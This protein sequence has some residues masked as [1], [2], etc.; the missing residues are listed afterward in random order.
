[1]KRKSLVVTLSLFAILAGAFASPASAQDARVTVQ[2]QSSFDKTIDQL[3]GAVSKGGMMVMGQVDQGNMLSM[4]GL[5]LKAT[6]FLVG[7][8]TVGK[9]LFEQDHG[10]GLYVPF[11]VFVTEGK[12]GK[13]YVSYDKASALLRQ[14]KNAD[15]DKTAAML[16]Q[17]LEGMAQMA[18]K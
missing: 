14:F 1:M 12:D 17:K 5:K 8:P 9:Q 13:V 16:D 15:I 4:A 6:L 2:S 3:K 11:R 7:N 18:A 10:V